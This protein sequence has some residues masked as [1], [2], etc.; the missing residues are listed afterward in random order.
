MIEETGVVTKTDGAMAK[1]AVQKRGACEGCAVRG[2]CET[3]DDGMEIEAF[4]PVQAQ[5]G[6]TVKIFIKPQ[7]YLK[8]T[9]IVYGIP[10]S[11]FIA[12]VIIGKNIGERYFKTISS[13]LV[14][15]IAGFSALILSFVIVKAWSK[16]V[17]TK[18]EYKP[19]IEEVLHE[20]KDSKLKM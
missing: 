5:I 7:T 8:G 3:S 9:I 2:V 19:V 18:V 17:E 13:D 20:S 10:L 6:Q 15:F 4:N 16:K 12:G 1:V 14:S 11:A